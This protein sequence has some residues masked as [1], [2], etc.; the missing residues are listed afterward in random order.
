MMS[1]LTSCV[2]AL[3]ALNV[4]TAAM[5]PPASVLKV[6]SLVVCFAGRCAVGRESSKGRASSLAVSHALARR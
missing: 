5:A 1:S 4:I 3:A 6:A 2:C